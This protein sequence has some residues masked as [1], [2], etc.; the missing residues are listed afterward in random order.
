MNF[1]DHELVVKSIVEF[2]LPAKFIKSS[3]EVRD[4]FM[5][6]CFKNLVNC[7]GCCVCLKLVA[8]IVAEQVVVAAVVEVVKVFLK[9]MH[10]KRQASRHAFVE[11]QE[12]CNFSRTGRLPVRHMKT[13]L[14]RN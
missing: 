14:S 8:E 5:E 10:T 9:L 2:G 12:L 1:E 3:K 13:T 11:N 7:S 4:E 6:A